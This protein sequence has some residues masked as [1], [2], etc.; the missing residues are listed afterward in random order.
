[1][2]KCCIND[3]STLTVCMTDVANPA[4]CPVP[5]EQG[6]SETGEKAMALQTIKRWGNS[7]AVRIPANVAEELHLREDQEV[8]IAVVDGV[9]VATPTIKTFNWD[10]YRD[11]LARMPH[12]LH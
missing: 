8:E 10:D 7:L 4:W 5:R 12:D 11:Q 1:M 3:V 2:R 9:F 6:S